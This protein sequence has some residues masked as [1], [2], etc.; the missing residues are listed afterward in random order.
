MDNA[1]RYKRIKVTLQSTL[2]PVALFLSGTSYDVRFW[3]NV[4]AQITRSHLV[5]RLP[6]PTVNVV[7]LVLMT[8]FSPPYYDIFVVQVDRFDQPIE[9]YGI[10]VWRDSVGFLLSLVV[11][12]IGIVFGALYEAWKSRFLT[13]EF[14]ESQHIGR[15]VIGTL[16]VVGIGGPILVIAR[17]NPDASLFVSSG[18]I[19]VVV[20]LI[21]FVCSCFKRSLQPHNFPFFP[22]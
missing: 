16:I 19:F 10:C 4:S 20:R 15:A 6:L 21:F 5:H 11:L 8:V 22:M 2:I 12:N 17:D 7:L 18:I 3:Y 1:K 14:A 13:T 9:T